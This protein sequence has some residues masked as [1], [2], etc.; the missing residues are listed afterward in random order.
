MKNKETIFFQVV[1]FSGFLLLLLSIY[2]RANSQ[3]AA[4][5]AIDVHKKF[6]EID[7]RAKHA[8]EKLSSDLNALAEYLLQGTNSES[9]RARAVFSWIAYHIRYDYGAQSLIEASDALALETLK[10]GKAVCEGYSA[11]FQTLGQKMNLQVKVIQGYSKGF[12]YKTGKKFTG[13]D[14]S[15]NAVLIDGEW[16]LMD[17]TWGAGYIDYEKGK[18]VFKPRFDP[19]WF[20]CEPEA[21]V[22]SHFPVDTDYLLFTPPITLEKFTLISKP[23]SDYFSLGFTGKESL[24][25]AISDPKFTF[26]PA[27]DLG[28]GIRKLECPAAENLKAGVNYKFEFTSEKEG[29]FWTLNN[30]EPLEFKASGTGFSSNIQPKKG[31]LYILFQ[32]SGSET[33]L[34]FLM[35]KVSP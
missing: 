4:G 33:M 6:A 35:Y 12:G 7:N 8:P 1:R 13:F 19:F 34:T 2:I 17:V 28:F 25:T 26:P 10:K 21:F 29:I 5:P 22:F 15:W 20:M 16:K 32:P 24:K 27:D 11:L 9:E 31:E 23:E 30:E 3:S 14:H 18:Y